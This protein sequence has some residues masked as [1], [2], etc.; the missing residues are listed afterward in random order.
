MRATLGNR[1][2]CCM[3]TVRW[4]QAVARRVPWSL[5]VVPLLLASGCATQAGTGGLLG[6]GIGG[7]AGA[8][9][10]HAAH[11]TAAGAVIGAAT[12]AVI[13]TAAG[14][15]ADERDHRRAVQAGQA[16]RGGVIPL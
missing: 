4:M 13:G 10:G 15:S 1:R 12:G 7:V 5:A 11:N 14:A 2:G 6:A 8:A 9:I 3:R 16:A